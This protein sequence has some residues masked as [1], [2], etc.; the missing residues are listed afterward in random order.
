LP[1]AIPYQELKIQ[2]VTKEG[3]GRNVLQ[4]EPNVI[5]AIER[6]KSAARKGEPGSAATGS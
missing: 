4:R 2:F 6:L 3:Y 1:K 5:A